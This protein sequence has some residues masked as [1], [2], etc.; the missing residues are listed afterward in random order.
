MF[1]DNKYFRLY[2]AIIERATLRSLPADVKT[3]IH[4]ILPRSLG[5]DDS[6]TNLVILTLKEHW[7]CHRLLVKFLIDKQHIRKMYNALYIMLCKDYRTV[8]ARIY[9]MVKMNAVP[10]NKGMRGIKGH[11]C[12][13]DTRIYLSSIHKG[14]KREDSHISAMR[15]GWARRKKEGHTPWNKGVRGKVQIDHLVT[16]ISPYGEHKT[17]RNL[18]EGCVD[19]NLAYTKMSSIQAN[20]G[21]H[22]N[23]WTIQ[24]TNENYYTRDELIMFSKNEITCP[25]CGTKLNNAGLYSRWHGNKCKNKE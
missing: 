2:N 8:N 13:D 21:T 5:G 3:E 20:N 24:G 11:A 17:Y 1:T 16:L 7:I 12:N 14:K 22:N 9:E 6:T 4:H 10:W 15:E 25:H 19:N 18:R 23:G